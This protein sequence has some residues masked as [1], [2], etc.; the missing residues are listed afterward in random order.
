[1]RII[2]PIARFS[3]AAVL[4]GIAVSAPFAAGFAAAFARDPGTVGV[5]FVFAAPVTCVC[6]AIGL[7]AFGRPPR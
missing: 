1:M 5:L 7:E 4:V 3:A 6:A 2:A